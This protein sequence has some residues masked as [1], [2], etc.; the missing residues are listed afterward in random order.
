MKIK[1]FVFNKYFDSPID[2]EKEV[3]KFILNKEIIDIKVDAVSGAHRNEH[4]EL[5]YTILY[6]DKEQTK[7]LSPDMEK[8]TE[9]VLN[10]IHELGGCDASE[11]WD[12]GWDE[13]INSVYDAVSDIFRKL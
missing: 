12:K 6:N 3:N 11:E 1:V 13:A 2:I 8:I 4:H 10:A 5:V 9:D 7:E